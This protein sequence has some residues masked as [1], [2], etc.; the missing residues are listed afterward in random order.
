MIFASLV[1]FSNFQPYLYFI[2]MEDQERKRAK[3]IFSFFKKKSGE[4]TSN[5]SLKPLSLVETST[6][7]DIPMILVVVEP[8]GPQPQ[9]KVSRIPF[10]E[11]ELD[12]DPALRIP[13]WKHLDYNQDEVRR[14]YI[15]W[16]P[17]QPILAEYLRT[18]I[19]VQNRRFQ[20]S[21]YKKFPWLEYSIAK[22][23]AF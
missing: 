14:A 8:Q 1:C 4:E 16:G 2:R 5:S 22:D 13:I 17:N 10:D 21:W 9:T 6:S 18:K 20:E 15:K 7:V 3:T 19:G 11:N 23:A 12:R